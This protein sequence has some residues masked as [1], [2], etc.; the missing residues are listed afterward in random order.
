MPKPAIFLHAALVLALV[1]T[2]TA[3]H[4]GEAAALF[5][6]GATFDLNLPAP[7]TV[8]DQQNHSFE[9][10]TNE[11]REIGLQNPFAYNGTSDVVVDIVARGNWQ[12]TPGTFNRG[13][14]PR[15]FAT[16]WTTTPPA[17]GTVDALAARMRVSF[18]CANA[19]EFGASCGPLEAGHVGDGRR[20]STFFFTVANGPPSSVAF[21]GLGLA[22]TS[23][24]PVSLT[25]FGWT[26]CHG[27][28]GAD[29]MVGVSTTAL[30]T[31]SHPLVVPNTAANDGLKVYGTWITLDPN[32]PGGLTF[33]NYTRMIVGL[34]P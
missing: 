24:F 2:L 25:P 8:L 15:V 20:N 11:W 7:V 4:D 27:W 17:T 5:M 23:P 6:P 34:E 14:E 10:A 3:Q 26:N 18:H 29:V 16:G 22:N 12:T 30:G 21:L 31:A 32:E 33:S 13:S 19:N 9:F 28:H 1:A